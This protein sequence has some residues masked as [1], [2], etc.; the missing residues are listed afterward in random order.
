MKPLPLDADKL[1]HVQKMILLVEGVKALG[2]GDL[3]SNI[4]MT[5]LWGS[6][7]VGR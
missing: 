7:L 2:K 5:V 6:A 4:E 1:K 3:S